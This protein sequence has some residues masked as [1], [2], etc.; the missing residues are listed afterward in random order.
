MV[1]IDVLDR[2]APLGPDV[3]AI[4]ERTDEIVLGR[5]TEEAEQN[6]EALIAHIDDELQVTSLEAKAAELDGPEA[7]ISAPSVAVADGAGRT[8]RS[9]LAAEF[10][11]EP[12]R[13]VEHLQSGDPVDRL[14]TAVN[15]IKSSEEVEK[16]EAYGQILFVSPAYRYRLTE[17]AMELV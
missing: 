16:S 14:N 9:I 10:G 6:L 8:I 1:E 13:V 12:E 15:A 4:S 7:R 5:V 3:F 2:T 17:Q 11:I